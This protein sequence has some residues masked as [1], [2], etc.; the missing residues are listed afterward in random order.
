MRIDPRIAG[1]G[2]AAAQ[3]GRPSGTTTFRL[4][5][6][7]AVSTAGARS[8]A[9][10]QTLDAILMLQGDDDQGGRERKRRAG[11]PRPRTCSTRSTG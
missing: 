11:P 3:A 10:L 9:P 2:A 7:R 5:S 1:Y 4:S 8:A 6:E